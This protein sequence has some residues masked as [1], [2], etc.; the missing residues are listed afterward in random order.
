MKRKGYL[1]HI[2]SFNTGHYKGNGLYKHHIVLLHCSRHGKRIYS[3]YVC[4]KKL[5][6]KKKKNACKYYYYK[7]FKIFYGRYTHLIFCCFFKLSFSVLAISYPKNN[8]THKIYK[9]RFGNSI[10]GNIGKE[11]L[12][13]VFAF[14]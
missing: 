11:T 2:V 9:V 5:D 12:P 13:A 6:A 7:R 8:N 1:H 3:C 14:F 10:F 4:N